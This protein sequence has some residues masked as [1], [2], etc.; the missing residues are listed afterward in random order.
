L[1]KTV[2]ISL[3]QLIIKNI[4]EGREEQGGTEGRGKNQGI[5]YEDLLEP[6]LHSIA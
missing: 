4:L 5:R 3:A 1:F 6:F 2:L